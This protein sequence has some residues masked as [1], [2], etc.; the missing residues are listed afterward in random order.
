MKFN[1]QAMSLDALALR[2]DCSA[3][4][5]RGLIARGDLAAFRIGRLF[6]VSLAEV[7]RFEQCPH[8]A[9]SASQAETP[10]TSETA[11]VVSLR[12]QR[13][14]RKL[15]AFSTDTLKPGNA[16]KARQSR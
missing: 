1:P 4:A 6:R 9:L 8:R 16:P 14:A 5:I 7:E 12:E 15:S 10:G 11:A 3:G 2:W 13:I